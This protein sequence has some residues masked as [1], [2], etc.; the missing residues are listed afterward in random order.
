MQIG[1]VP[2]P[3]SPIADDHFHVGAAPAAMT[4]FRIQ[5][6]AELL[7]GLDGTGVGGRERVANSKAFLVIAGLGKD[8]SQF[9]FPGTR[10]LAVDFSRPTFGRGAHHGYAGAVELDIEHG[11]GGTMGMGRSNCRARFISACWRAA[12]SAPIASAV[13]S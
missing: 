8:A 2:D 11:N 10:G 3:F 7:C 9:D 6:L 4:G 1:E 12:M 5:A 13:R